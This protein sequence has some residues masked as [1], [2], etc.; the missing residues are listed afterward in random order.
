MKEKKISMAVSDAPQP[1]NKFQ[2]RTPYY[3]LSFTL[4]FDYD[5]DTVFIA[6]SRPY[7]FSKVI[8]DIVDLEAQMQKL[9]SN[10]T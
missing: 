7:K 3:C 1:E 8:S 2:Y 5:D 10:K 4:K 9:E 6:Y